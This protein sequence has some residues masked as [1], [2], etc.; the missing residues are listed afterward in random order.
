MKSVKGGRG[1]PGLGQVLTK[2][3]KYSFIQQIHTP[4]SCQEPGSIL[5]ARNT[6]QSFLP[7]GARLLVGVG[8][9]INT[10]NKYIFYPKVASTM[11]ERVKEH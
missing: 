8:V 7:L 3:I 5:S 11:G 9:E 6:K 1:E 10:C 2:L 4:M